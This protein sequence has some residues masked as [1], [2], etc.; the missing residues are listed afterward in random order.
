[1]SSNQELQLFRKLIHKTNDAIFIADA[2][3]ARIIDV[4]DMACTSTGYNREELLSMHVMDMDAVTITP[5]QWKEQVKAFRE[6]G[7]IIEVSHR[8]K[9]GTTFPVEISVS[10]YPLDDHNGYIIGIARDITDR[11]RA[12]EELK[13]LH[14]ILIRQASSDPLTGISNRT[15]FNE[16]L[17]IEIA[18]SK[19][20][21]LPL[22]LIM[23]DIDR[24]K[25]IND[26]YGHNVGDNVLREFAS[27]V[28][29]SIRKNDLFTRWGGEEFI[30]LIT[31]V[32]RSGTVIFAEKLR[33]EIETF[34]FSPV[35]RITCS[36]GVTEFEKNDTID[37]FIKKADIAL[38]RAKSAGRNRV[39]SS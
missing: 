9:D 30:I 14:E 12:N 8:R 18:R 34:D 7:N 16:V 24:F 21:T 15:K 39:E 22:S 20:F 17:G 23:M 31:N 25:E 5:S 2:E 11:N 28:S 26:T 4:N 33:L 13:R 38:Y 29:K 36:F 1:M 32:T 19:R 37:S 6:K 3:T 35:G 27:R 10:Y